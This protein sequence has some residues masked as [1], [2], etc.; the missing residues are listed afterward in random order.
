MHHKLWGTAAQ[1]SVHAGITDAA[2]NEEQI[3]KGDH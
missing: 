2:K 1:H 3:E